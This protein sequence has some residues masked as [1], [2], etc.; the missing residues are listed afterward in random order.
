MRPRPTIRVLANP[1]K[2]GLRI[3]L[4]D[5]RGWLIKWRKITAEGLQHTESPLAP[6]ERGPVA[7]P[8]TPYYRQLIAQ[9]DLVVAA[10][11]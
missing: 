10:Q 8:S 4:F 1:D 11:E 7:V 5:E 6:L 3:D 2:P 9:G